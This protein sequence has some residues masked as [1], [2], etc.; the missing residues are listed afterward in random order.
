MSEEEGVTP[1]DVQHDCTL[2]TVTPR[3]RQ[4][5]SRYTAGITQVTLSGP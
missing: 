5:G 4:R 1:F 2:L 3:G